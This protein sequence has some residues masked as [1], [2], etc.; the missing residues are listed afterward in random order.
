[1][2]TAVLILSIIY[3]GGIGYWAVQKVDAFISQFNGTEQS[4]GSVQFHQDHD[5]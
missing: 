2:K 1:M 3:A 4:K 5:S